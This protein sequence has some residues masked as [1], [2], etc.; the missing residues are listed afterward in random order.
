MD[1][2]SNSSRGSQETLGLEQDIVG[3]EG[4]QG[5]YAFLVRLKE[6]FNRSG[7]ALLLT[8]V[9]VG[10]TCIQV[11]DSS[12]IQLRSRQAV[13]HARQAYDTICRRRSQFSFSEQ[14]AQALEAKLAELKGGLARLGEVL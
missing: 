13:R 8:D 6:D 4:G 9:E 12:Y 1:G 7:V 5:S 14:Q 2:V 3:F 10:L 11:A